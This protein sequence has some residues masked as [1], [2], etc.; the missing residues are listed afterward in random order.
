MNRLAF[1]DTNI[2]LYSDDVSNSGKQ[3]LAIKLIT[4]YQRAGLAA[5]SLQVMQEYFSAATRKL[6]LDVELAQW[7]VEV[8]SRFRVVRI[9]EADVIAAI[10]LHRLHHV[11]FWDALIVQA[12]RI[13]GAEIL[14]SEDMQ[15]GSRL[16]GVTIV[17]PFDTGAAF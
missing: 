13:S 2:F 4:A 12:A 10:E 17:N 7:K 16:G 6:G 5:V 9:V 1:F 14:F 3:A 11:S 8:I 15:S